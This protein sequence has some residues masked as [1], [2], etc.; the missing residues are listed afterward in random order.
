LEHAHTARGSEIGSQTLHGV[1]AAGRG[2]HGTYCVGRDVVYVSVE[3]SERVA[4]RGC[5]VWL[6]GAGVDR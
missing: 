5:G 4:G 2:L 1:G 6:G 3:V